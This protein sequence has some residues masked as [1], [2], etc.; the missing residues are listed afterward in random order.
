[1][2]TVRPARLVETAYLQG[3]LASAPIDQVD[4][5]K[6]IVF[7]A[8]D[9]GFVVG[10][11]AAHLTWRIEP[12]FL[13]PEFKNRAPRALLRRATLLLGREIDRYIL[14]KAWN[15]TRI[16]EYFAFVRKE[17]S[18][19]ARHFGLRSRPKDEVVLERS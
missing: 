4:L 16:H 13:F 8:E 7:V 3:R 5:K 10:F 1:M 12:L 14:D 11:V 17:F 19:L 15:R 18:D 9:D 6:S 2:I